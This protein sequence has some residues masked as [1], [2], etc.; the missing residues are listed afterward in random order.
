M[1]VV[2]WDTIGGSAEAT[3]NLPSCSEE[4]SKQTNTK[5]ERNALFAKHPSALSNAKPISLLCGF[6]SGF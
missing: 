6:M 4:I 3:S 5:L 1:K 2:Y